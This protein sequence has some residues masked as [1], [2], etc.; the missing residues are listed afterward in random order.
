M[1]RCYTCGFCLCKISTKFGL[2]LSPTFIL[3]QEIFYF[4]MD[5]FGDSD[6]FL[7]HNDGGVDDDDDEDK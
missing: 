1:W 6:P 4:T 3:K 2:V 5:D 7:K